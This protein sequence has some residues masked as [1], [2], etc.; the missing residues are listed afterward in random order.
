MPSTPSTRPAVHAQ[1]APV[2][3]STRSGHLSRRPCAVGTCPAVH[4]QRA[5]SQA[6]GYRLESQLHLRPAKCTLD[7]PGPGTQSVT[8]AEARQ[9]GK[10]LGHRRQAPQGWRSGG[11]GGRPPGQPP[12]HGGPRPAPP[13]PPPPVLAVT[14]P[15]P[16]GLHFAPHKVNPPR[17]PH[18]RRPGIYTA[19]R[20]DSPGTAA[21][22]QG[23]RRGSRP[24]LRPCPVP[25]VPA[26]HAGG[27]RPRPPRGPSRGAFP[28]A[29]TPALV[30][31]LLPA[32]EAPAG[33]RSSPSPTAG[34]AAPESRTR[35][36]RSPRAARAPRLVSP[37]PGLRAPR[38][39]PR[40]HRPGAADAVTPPAG[41][42]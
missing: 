37:T 35:T 31:R 36:G 11:S 30:P 2:P 8:R 10:Q 32:R 17:P 34:V 7:T 4:A 24:R 22:T 20:T 23:G 42:G 27:D 29:Q 15:P 26:R 18:G 33:V 39:A 28:V 3:P 19:L 38:P 25:P 6:E 16:N 41:L 5:L 12:S 9:P 1:W 14:A 13:P 21:Q 40:T